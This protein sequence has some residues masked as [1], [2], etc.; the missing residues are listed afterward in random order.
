[1]YE[2]IVVL[3]LIG[4]IFAGAIA[5]IGARNRYPGRQSAAAGRRSCGAA[6]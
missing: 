1:M 6:C 2:A 4:A 3:P 5:L